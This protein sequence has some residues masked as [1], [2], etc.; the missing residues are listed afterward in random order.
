MTTTTTAG[1]RV[2]T[3]SDSGTL[4]LAARRARDIEIQ[5]AG[6]AA[7]A[8]AARAAFSERTSIPLPSGD[9]RLLPTD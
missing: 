6:D 1:Q 5:A 9:T 8:A 3:E 2:E 4:W 7:A